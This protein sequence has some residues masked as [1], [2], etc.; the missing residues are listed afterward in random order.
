MELLTC[1]HV[2]RRLLSEYIDLPG[3]SLTSAQA[4]RLAGVDAP[5]CQVVL[6]ELVNAGCLAQA[7]SRR[8]VREARYGELE[9]RLAQ[10]ANHEP[11]VS[12]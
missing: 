7:P 1:K 11:A 5:A 12:V 4:A 3:L 10:G 2:E 9:S 6:D 8:Y